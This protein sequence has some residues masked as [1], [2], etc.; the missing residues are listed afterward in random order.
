VSIYLTGFLIHS[1]YVRSA[2]AQNFSITRAEYIETGFGFWILTS[3]LAVVPVFSFFLIRA[4]RKKLHADE[5]LK[6]ISKYGIRR[7]TIVVANFSIV[8]MFFAL[9][10][11]NYEW[12][13]R[14]FG[15]SGFEIKDLFHIYVWTVSIGVVLAS[16]LENLYLSVKRLLS[17]HKLERIGSADASHYV[18]VDRIV[19]RIVG[20][21]RWLLLAASLLFDFL[22]FSN[23]SWIGNAIYTAR[24]YFL[25]L[26]FLCFIIYRTNVSLRRVSDP[27]IRFRTVLLSAVLVIAVLQLTLTGFSL[28]VYRFMPASRGG[29]LPQVEA[30][31]V[32]KPEAL[33]GATDLP[34]TTT[35]NAIIVQHLFIIEQ[36]DQRHY[37]LGK[38]NPF[39]EPE[40]GVVHVFQKSDLL[41]MRFHAVDLRTSKNKPPSP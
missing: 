17:K 3:V 26:G 25:L 24:V 29:K 35:N 12:E 8:L 32:L 2:G 39:R 4:Y 5:G 27:K 16:E 30:E 19:V 40:F 21:L 34:Y 6:S 18:I 23:I 37:V 22:L 36:D 13:T 31:M 14:V 7:S 38:F 41:A 28:S 1:T 9:F 10:V 20:G 11:T 33:I 15:G